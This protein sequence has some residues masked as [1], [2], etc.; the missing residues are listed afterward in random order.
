M[1]PRSHFELV[2]INAFRQVVTRHVQLN[3]AANVLQGNE[4]RFTHNTTGHHAASNSHFNVQR[5]Q[6]FI[7][8]AIEV[9][10][11]LVRGM[12]TTEIVRESDALL[13]Q[14]SQLLATGFQ[15]IIKV[16]CR[17]SACACC[18][19]MLVPHNPAFKLASINWSRLP[20]STA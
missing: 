2:V 14:R 1:S 17:V 15:F 3:T 18:S 19:D 6:L 9:S 4:R 5:F 11:Q 7:F 10:V 20:S 13:T 8:F 16:N 12:V